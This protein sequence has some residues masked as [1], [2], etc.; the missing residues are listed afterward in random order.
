MQKV[1]YFKHG[2]GTTAKFLTALKTKPEEFW[3]RRGEKMALKL[4]KD[5]SVRV[6]AYRDFLKKQ[7]VKSA[8]IKN[9]KD[10]QQIP[11][12]DKANY[13]RQYDLPDLCWD[14][15]FS[16]ENWDI[17]STS[18]STGEPY[19]FPRNDF[20]NEYY[21]LTAEL[22]LRNN[23][24]IQKR[25][26]LY[27][28]CFALGVW[29]GGLFTYE[30]IKTVVRR[31]NYAMSLINPGLNKTEI[32]KSIKKLAP[33][34]DQIILAGYPPFIK[35]VI[36]DGQVAGLNWSEYNMKFIFSAEAFSEKFRDY[37]YKAT[38][39][40]NVYLDS[41][42]HYGTVDQGTL[43]HETPLAILLRRQALKDE[44]LRSHIFPLSVDRLPTLGQYC[45]EMFYF[46]E[47]KSSLLCSSFSG[48]PLVRY[49]LNDQGGIITSKNINEFLS[50]DYGGIK[51]L[52]SREGVAG[53]V[54][55]LPFV[56]VYERQDLSV[57]FCGANIYP[58]HIRSVVQHPDFSESL[59]GKFSLL[60]K[61]N[62][63]Q[64][65]YLEINFEFKKGATIFSSEDFSKQLSDRIT[66][67]LLKNNSEYRSV[68]LDQKQEKARPVLVFWEYESAQF[69]KSGG[70]HKWVVK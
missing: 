4:F 17:S 21:A 52:S 43:A 54:W 23:F 19:Y 56:Y 42:N 69:F 44:S 5:M 38:G 7:G 59:S 50:K 62:E 16:S 67:H 20:Q 61:H 47:E 9:I 51:K 70:K 40:H 34:F 29:I 11:T 27:V 45:P 3:I 6:P 58:E 55:N 60:V 30:A 10:F 68:Y 53:L 48:L 28:N 13:L 12:I 22:Y 63:N 26:T 64:D 41:L 36:D 37:I 57:S 14:G 15:K 49:N 8:L 65:P 32:L 46:E 2:F 66:D 25:K 39:E 1:N 31:G 33:Y 24:L 18:G 35:D